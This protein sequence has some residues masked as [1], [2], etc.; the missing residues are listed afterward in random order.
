[1]FCYTSLVHMLHACV[2]C[3]CTGKEHAAKLTLL[4]MLREATVSLMQNSASDGH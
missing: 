3:L 2:A 1:M 4:R